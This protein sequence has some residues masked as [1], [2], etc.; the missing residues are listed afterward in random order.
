M[1][2]MQQKRKTRGVLISFVAHAWSMCDADS[3]MKRAAHANRI[4]NCRTGQTFYHWSRTSEKKLAKPSSFTSLHAHWPRDH[5]FRIENARVETTHH[6]NV[7]PNMNE[8]AAASES[9]CIQIII[10]F[11]RLSSSNQL[12]NWQII[13]CG[14]GVRAPRGMADAITWNLHDAMS[15][16]PKWRHNTMVWT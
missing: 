9:K 3:H 4:E 5:F 8:W 10:D 15:M 1:N 14:L 7:L 13:Y 2:S 11:S 16:C 12:L 6:V